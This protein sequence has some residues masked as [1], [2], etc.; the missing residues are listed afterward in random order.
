MPTLKTAEIELASDDR[1]QGGAVLF[2]EQIDSS[3]AA[4]AVRGGLGDLVQILDSR[5][6]II[7]SRQEF[8]IPAIGCSHQLGHNRQTVDR[9]LHGSVLHLP[10]SISM[11]YP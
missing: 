4:L 5:R 9:L 8:Q 7:K 3:I 2:G 1:F 10:G 6:R 11:F